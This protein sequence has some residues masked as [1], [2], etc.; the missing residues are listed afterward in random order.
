LDVKVNGISL[1]DELLFRFGRNDLLLA[2]PTWNPRWVDMHGRD[3]LYL[4]ALGGHLS[5]LKR[6]VQVYP[7]NRVYLNSTPLTAA[8][9]TQQKEEI[10]FTLLKTPDIHVSCVDAFMA[11]R[12]LSLP[13]LKTLFPKNLFMDSS[14]LSIALERGEEFVK[15]LIMDVKVDVSKYGTQR[16]SSLHLQSKVSL[17]MRAQEKR[18]HPQIIEMLGGPKAPPLRFPKTK[19]IK[20]KGH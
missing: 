18:F 3:L 7:I 8:L 1:L 4:A 19:S 12:Y 15:F 6:A 16:S 9:G 10:I 5:L 2:I 17:Y 13:T 20:A 11:F 14:L